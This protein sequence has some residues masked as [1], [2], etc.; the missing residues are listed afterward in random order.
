MGTLKNHVQL[1]GHLGRDVE[2]TS[3]DSGTKMAKIALATNDFYTN[4]DGE[5]VKNTEWH[6]IIAWGKLAENMAGILKKGNEV[7]IQ[8]K[9]VHRSYE[10]KDG[11]NHYVTE[12]VAN[13]FF[14]ISKKADTE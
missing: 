7:A 4:G 12:V 14:K 8:G 10:G 11:H 5:K 6:N 13:E 1:I 2:F 9:L 3:F